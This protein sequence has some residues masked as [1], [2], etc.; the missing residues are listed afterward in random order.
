MK[1]VSRWMAEWLLLAL[2]PA[3]RE[4]VRGDLA[5]S[6]ETASQ[7]LSEVAGLVLRRQTAMWT[8]WRP[9]AALI[10]L[11][12]IAAMALSRL[13]F[14]LNVDISEQFRT[15]WPYGEHSENGLTLTQN[16]I[17]CCC[18]SL[19]LLTWAWTSGFV[20]GSLS[21][22][23]IWL[24]GTLFYLAL[25]DSFWVR[26]TLSGNIVIGHVPLISIIPYLA[27]PLA[28]AA[29]IVVV[30]CAIWGIWQGIRSHTLALQRAMLLM[31]ATVVL[32]SL[33]FWTDGW[34]ECAHE[35]WSEGLWRALPWQTR[36]APLIL[37]SW[38]AGYLLASAM[39]RRRARLNRGED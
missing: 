20:L 21:K 22:R 13:T 18:R 1:R 35:A 3:E 15:Y 28:G 36:L 32:T 6:G 2:E 26:L 9:W 11:V 38:P 4:V 19:A 23:T 31:T 39:W 29:T 14:L 7:A 5:E 24:T 33:V 34:A 27:L 16:V 8:D 37:A 30:L 17:S 25:I 10:G 12:G